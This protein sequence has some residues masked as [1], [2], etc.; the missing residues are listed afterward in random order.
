MTRLP[1]PGHLILLSTAAAVR[2][3]R[4]SWYSFRPPL[5]ARIL[6]ICCCVVTITWRPGLPWQPPT[7]LPSTR[8]AQSWNQRQRASRQAPPRTPI[9]Y[10][11]DEPG[12]RSCWHL[13]VRRLR[14]LPAARTG[15]LPRTPGSRVR[16]GRRSAPM[17]GDGSV[18][19]VAVRVAERSPVRPTWIAG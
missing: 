10:R 1:G 13:V 5:R 9:P 2:P 18:E 6:L 4:W 17:V 12:R 3:D 11:G 14:R 16:R 19:R 7:L 15:W 8:Q